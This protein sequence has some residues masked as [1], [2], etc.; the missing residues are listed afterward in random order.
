MIE[1]AHII[2]AA[3]AL[4]ISTIFNSEMD[5][6]LEYRK[7]PHGSKRVVWFPSL[8][9]W[10]EYRH[11]SGLGKL[12]PFRDGWH[13]AKGVRVFTLLLPFAVLLCAFWNINPYWSLLINIPLFPVQGI[14]FELSYEN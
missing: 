5:T 3:V 7:N 6:I 12:N 8:E 10:W 2:I 1:L 14:F 13:F 9:W 11:A 4:I